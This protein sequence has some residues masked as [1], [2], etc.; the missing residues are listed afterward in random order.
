MRAENYQKPILLWHFNKKVSINVY[1]AAACACC[2]TS[3]LSLLIVEYFFVEEYRQTTI[4]AVGNG[5]GEATKT[6]IN[7][8]PYDKASVCKLCSVYASRQFHTHHI[9]RCCIDNNNRQIL[10]HNNNAKE[11]L[12][13]QNIS[14][15]V[16]SLRPLFKHMNG[17]RCNEAKLNGTTES[18]KICSKSEPTLHFAYSIGRRQPQRHGTCLARCGFLPWL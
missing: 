2:I 10:R 11:K 8:P 9:F 17:R 5:D 7:V 1:N 4:T 18:A 12:K 3:V 6:L 14:I 15:D 13:M 16:A